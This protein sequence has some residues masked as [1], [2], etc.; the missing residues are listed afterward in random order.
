[1]LVTHGLTYLSQCDVI[2]TMKDGSIRE[3]GTYAELID[4]NGAF[5]EFMRTYASTEDNDEEKGVV[6]YFK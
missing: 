4:S 2:V 3:V 5:A 6:N 1:M